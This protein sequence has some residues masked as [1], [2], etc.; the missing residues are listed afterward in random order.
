M[1]TQKTLDKIITIIFILFIGFVLGYG[2]RMY[3]EQTFV[4]SQINGQI[5][6]NLNAIEIN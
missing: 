6:D 4:K 1:I 2:L 3:H 5:Y